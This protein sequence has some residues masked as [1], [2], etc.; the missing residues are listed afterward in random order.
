MKSKSSIACVFQLPAPNILWKLEVGPTLVFWV[1]VGH[2][3]M[4]IDQIATR[5][6]GFV[7]WILPI[8]MHRNYMFQL[9][10][11]FGHETFYE[12]YLY[13]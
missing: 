9:F 11:N 8:R 5:F 2:A 3:R 1:C 6:A 4:G 10:G 13:G 12:F 7:K